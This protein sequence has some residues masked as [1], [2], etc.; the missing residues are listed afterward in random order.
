MPGTCARC[1]KSVFHAEQTRALGKLWHT[2]CFVCAK[3]G[4]KKRLVSTNATDHEGE[5]FCKECHAKAFGP[6]GYGYGMG[7]A[8]PLTLSGPS[9]VSSNMTGLTNCNS[10]KKLSVSG[11]SSNTYSP[12]I[13]QGP[14]KYSAYLSNSPFSPKSP[15]MKSI[16]QHSGNQFGGGDICGR[17]KKKVYGAEKVWGAGHNQPWHQTCFNCKSCGRRLDSK[18]L[19]TYQGEMYCVACYNKYH[20]HK[21]KF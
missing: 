6:K 19:Q 14:V 17:C 1:R 11:S 5:V 12:G 8:G 4:C 9:S 13:D 10:T 15:S 21:N 2:N 7:T 20:S 3:P 16:A 18:T